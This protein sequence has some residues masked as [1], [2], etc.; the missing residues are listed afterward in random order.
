MKKG[1][2]NGWDAETYDNV[3]TPQ[4]DFALKLVQL[5]S[6]TGNETVMDAGCGSGRVTKILAKK[7]P[8]G[9]I[10]AVDNDVNMIDKAKYNLSEFENIAIINSNLLN[11]N[12]IQFHQK[13]M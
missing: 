4:E 12:L 3:S 9:R 13:W 11:I 2:D 5:R 1:E 8:N 7:I 6:W 10:Y